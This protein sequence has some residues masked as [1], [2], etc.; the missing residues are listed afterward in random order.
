L[1]QDPHA[2]SDIEKKTRESSNPPNP[3][4]DTYGMSSP[5]NRL[6]KAISGKTELMYDRRQSAARRTSWR[7][8]RRESDWPED[9]ARARRAA[10][11]GRSAKR[12]THITH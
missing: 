8:G 4:A 7:G 6:L 5:E 9:F 1:S 3:S 10:K 2:Q 11:R 12:R